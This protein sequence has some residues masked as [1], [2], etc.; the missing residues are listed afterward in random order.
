MNYQNNL[1]F[2]MT[3]TLIFISLANFKVVLQVTWCIN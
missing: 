3:K 2:A 1:D